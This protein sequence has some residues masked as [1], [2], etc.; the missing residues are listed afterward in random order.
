M[1]MSLLIFSWEMPQE[2]YLVHLPFL[3]IFISNVQVWCFCS[4]IKSHN[5]LLRLG[6]LQRGSF[7]LWSVEAR[8]SCMRLLVRY[9]NPLASLPGSAGR[10][11]HLCCIMSPKTQAPTPWAFPSP[12]GAVNIYFLKTQCC[13]QELQEHSVNC[14]PGSLEVYKI[15]LL[16]VCQSSLEHGYRLL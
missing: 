4:W 7:T 14:C 12:L 15:Q 2:K 9:P 6:L 13:L 3:C 1:L 8:P 11:S 5:P 10:V 16:F